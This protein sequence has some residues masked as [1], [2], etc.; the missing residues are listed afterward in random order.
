MDFSDFEAGVINFKRKKKNFL[1]FDHLCSKCISF[2]V[3]PH[4]VKWY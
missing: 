4:R 1:T 2:D 3:Q